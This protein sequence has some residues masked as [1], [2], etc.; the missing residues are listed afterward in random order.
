MKGKN[1]YDI[2]YD[3]EGD[4]LEVTFGEPIQEEYS[5]EI[6]PGVFVTKDEET[7]EVKGI[8]ILS[9]KKRV[10]ILKRLLNQMDIHLPIEISLPSD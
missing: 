6:E 7:E 3:E 8:S 4:F 2:Y 10:Q 5:N 1:T 9:F